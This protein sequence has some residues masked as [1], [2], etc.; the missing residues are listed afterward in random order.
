MSKENILSPRNNSDISPDSPR[1][2]FWS[3]STG[4]ELRLCLE[5]PP[6]STI[7]SMVVKVNTITE[8]YFYEIYVTMENGKH[9]K[10][11]Y[12]KKKDA[13]KVVKDQWLKYYKDRTSVEFIEHEI[14]DISMLETNVPCSD[15]SDS[16][17]PRSPLTS[18]GRL[19][20]IFVDS[21]PPSPSPRDLRKGSFKNMMKNIALSYQ[22]KKSP[23]SSSNFS[24]NSSSKDPSPRSMEGS[25]RKNW[26]HR[27]LSRKG[28]DGSPRD[29]TESNGGST[30]ISPRSPLPGGM[31][32]RTSRLLRR[33]SVKL[34]L[35]TSQKVGSGS[36]PGSPRTPRNSESLIKS[37]AY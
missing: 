18:P 34:A 26:V 35:Q 14:V 3:S 17:S 16:F 5:K 1:H 29:G 4:S 13:I 21:C 27:N 11:L 30:D 19:N 33:A 25:P 31:S 23:R 6:S 20:H 28:S 37:S 8:P 15:L 2:P 9:E 12:L 10:S 32:P 22:H 24:S 7:K 36:R